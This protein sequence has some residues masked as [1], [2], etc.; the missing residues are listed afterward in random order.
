MTPNAIG[1]NPNLLKLIVKLLF[2]IFIIASLKLTQVK[3]APKK[4]MAHFNPINLFFN[5]TF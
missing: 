3:L 1:L 2:V 5:E 4:D